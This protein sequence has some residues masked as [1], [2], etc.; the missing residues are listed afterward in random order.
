MSSTVSFSMEEPSAG[1]DV[2]MEP[3]ELSTQQLL[4]SVAATRRTIGTASDLYH[5]MT[6]DAS[7][8]ESIVSSSDED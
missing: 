6:S 1:L 8:N 5:S 7:S 2:G 4:R 3:D